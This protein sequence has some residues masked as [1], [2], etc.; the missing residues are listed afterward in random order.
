MYY[1]CVN[2]VLICGN[3]N[4]DELCYFPKCENLLNSLNPQLYMDDF[5]DDYF[6]FG[7]IF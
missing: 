5:N 4:C 7:G 3:D 6:I 1:A 2:H